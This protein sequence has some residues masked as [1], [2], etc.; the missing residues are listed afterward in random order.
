M[1]EFFKNLNF[2]R[3]VILLSALVSCALGYFVY[4][5]QQRMIEIENEGVQARGLVRQ[6]QELGFSIEELSVLRSGEGLIGVSDD[7]E[8]YV[9]RIAKGPLVVMGDIVVSPTTRT[10]GAG[11]EDVIYTLRS[12]DREADFSRTALGNFLFKLEADSKRVVVTKVEFTPGNG[13]LR[14]GEIGD[15]RWSFVVD[16]TTRQR[17][18]T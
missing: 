3:G 1:F 10:A 9:R 8:L 18:D 12:S 7:V 16:V 4:T 13:R 17:T 15:D 2:P 6:I 11:L 14:P 5:G